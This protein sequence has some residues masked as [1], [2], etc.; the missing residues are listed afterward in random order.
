MVDRRSVI[1]ASLAGAAGTL[2]GC[3]TGTSQPPAS[4]AGQVKLTILHHVPKD[5]VASDR[6]YEQV[7][8]PL[9]AA[10]KGLG[11]MERSKPMPLSP[12]APQPYHR[13]VEFWF[14]NQEHFRTVMGSP[15]WAM[16]SADAKNFATNGIT[17]VISRIT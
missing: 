13:M 5:P 9:V 17:V 12:T 7:H 11:R 8:M 1:A 16:V 10:V 15:E 14:D 3:A 6:H 4:A 2:G